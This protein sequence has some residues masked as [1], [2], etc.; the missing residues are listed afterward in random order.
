VAL[1]AQPA[2]SVVMP[3][4]NGSRYIQR[5]LESLC[6]QSYQVSE[7]IVVDDGSTDETVP[8][9]ESFQSRLPL[10]LVHGEHTGNWVKNTNRALELVSGD[11]VS[12]L[13][14]DDFWMPHRL[15]VICGVFQREPSVD[16]V[17]H[18]AHFVDP[19]DL[20]LG[21][22]R[23]PFPGTAGMLNQRQFLH[24]LI[25]QNFIAI[26]TPAIRS[27]VLK[28][29]GP[30]DET[31]WFTADWDLWLRLAQ[32]VQWYYVPQALAAFRVHW[33]SQTVAARRSIEDYRSQ[34]RIVQERFLSCYTGEPAE[35]DLLGRVSEASTAINIALMSMLRARK[36]PSLKEIR[37]VVTL[38]PRGWAQLVKNSR[39]HERLGA[40]LRL[41]A[42]RFN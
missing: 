15:A 39:I 32:A 22:L 14:Q 21:M 17:F 25:V 37:Q 38:G 28:R 5:C 20:T 16:V 36:V 12:L 11:V 30:L 18:P 33:E 35:V 10:R 1:I 7:I 42:R 27:A 19:A 8:I 24:S 2:V 4:Y 9:L 6:D 40:R 13:H 34:Y 31:L 26:P 23:A 41:M 3:T 29:M